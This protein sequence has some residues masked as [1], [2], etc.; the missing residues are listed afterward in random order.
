MIL[1]PIWHVLLQAESAQ[2]PGRP[3]V[4][5]I[6]VAGET[7]MMGEDFHAPAVQE[8]YVNLSIRIRLLFGNM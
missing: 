7:R 5:T 8:L 1:S 3:A 2:A 6:R 4:A